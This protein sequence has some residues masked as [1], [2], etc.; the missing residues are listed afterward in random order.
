MDPSGLSDNID[1]GDITINA[2]TASEE[3]P[4]N[5][6]TTDSTNVSSSGN[7]TQPDDPS[8]NTLSNVSNESSNPTKTA[9]ASESTDNSGYDALKSAI[10]SYKFSSV[11]KESWLAITP[12]LNILVTDA[13]QKFAN[14]M[15][16]QKTNAA[17]SFIDSLI[18]NGKVDPEKGARFLTNISTIKWCTLKVTFI[19]ISNDVLTFFRVQSSS[20]SSSCSSSSSLPSVTSS[21]G[22]TLRSSPVDSTVFDIESDFPSKGLFTTYTIFIALR[23]SFIKLR[24]G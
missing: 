9:N 4:L 1:S 8:I 7:S 21:N 12:Y 18:H 14:W 23:D 22:S 11:I 16:N 20:S 3:V 6:S 13:D 5:D 10:S 2:K 15:R 17:K 19:T 24:L